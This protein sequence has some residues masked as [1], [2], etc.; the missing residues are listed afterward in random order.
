MDA[1]LRAPSLP[2]SPAQHQVL[3]QRFLAAWHFFVP[4]DARLTPEC[5]A[6]LAAYDTPPRAYHTLAHLTDVLDQLDWAKTC[7]ADATPDTFARIEL[8]LFYHDAVY[9]PRATDNEAQSRNLFMHHAAAFGMHD[10]DAAAIARL[11]D[12]TAA[13][14]QA[15]A[16]DERILCDCDL[17]ILGAEQP[18][19]AAYDRN[20]RREYAH[21]P[22][23]LYTLRRAAVLHRFLDQPRLFNTAAFHDRYDAQARA[24]LRG[25][26]ESSVLA[27]LTRPFTR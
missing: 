1:L 12:I 15:S 9:D 2:A 21:V 13:H 18:A 27:R 5:L 10:D 4:A 6:V 14:T 3:L 26:L 20:I 19:F 24:N 23:P 8:A 17:A 25:A 11:I 22:A 16:L 7:I